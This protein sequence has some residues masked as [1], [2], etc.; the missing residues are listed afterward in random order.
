MIFISTSSTPNY[1]LTFYSNIEHCYYMPSIHV[2]TASNSLLISRKKSHFL[3]C[4]TF[5][6]PLVYSNPMSFFV[7]F[8]LLV[9]S[10]VLSI[11]HIIMLFYIKKNKNLP[12]EYSN[13]MTLIYS[14]VQPFLESLLFIHD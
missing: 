4:N 5:S 1:I 10:K 9:S 7:I 11:W 13:V 12:R 6:T 14:N 8:Q 2:I 3:D